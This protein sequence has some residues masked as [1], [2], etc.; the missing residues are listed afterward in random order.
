MRKYRILSFHPGRQHNLEQAHQIAKENESFRHITSLYFDNRIIQKCK[1]FSRRL[2]DVLKKRSSTIDKKFVH[3]YPLLEIKLLIK[4]SLSKNFSNADYRERNKLFQQ[5]IIRKYLPPTICI[6][7]DTSSWLVFEK[8]KHKSF[9]ILDLSIAV[10]QY[11]LE[12]SKSYGQTEEFIMKQTEGD[13]ASYQVYEK[14]LVLADLI[15]CGSDFV[16]NSCLSMGINPAKLLVLPYGADLNRFY[17]KRQ[18]ALNDKKI[19]IAF[20]GTFGYRKGADITLKAWD[21]IVAKYPFAELHIYGSVQIPL[22]SDLERIFLHGFVSQ[23]LLVQELRTADISILPTFFEGSSLAVYQSMA[24]GLA[25]ITTPN[26][27]SIIQDKI[28]GLIIPYGSVEALVNSLEVLIETPIFRKQLGLRA[29]N[30]VKEYSW[31]SY[32]KKLQDI[33]RNVITNH[34]SEK[35]IKS[36]Y[37]PTIE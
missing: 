31:E 13:S 10:P 4:R 14:E 3:T 27:G 21:S 29:Q 25:V 22:P 15:L 26:A 7:F 37:G 28:N 20:V 34:V 24:M 33:L 16:R 8:W 9:L 23:E 6:G 11:K 2:S 19:K 18:D 32:G 17:A 35:K 36:Q 5:W 1:N 30:D 12:L